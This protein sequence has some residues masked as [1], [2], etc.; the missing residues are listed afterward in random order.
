MA[1]ELTI[2]IKI[3]LAAADEF[4]GSETART[5]SAS[6]ETYYTTLSRYIAL[7]VQRERGQ[8]LGWVS[9]NYQPCKLGKELIDE[10]HIIGAREYGGASDPFCLPAEL[11]DLLTG[12]FYDNWD[13][14][15]AY[16]RYMKVKTKNPDCLAVLDEYLENSSLPDQIAVYYGVGRDAVKQLMHSLSMDGS[17]AAWRE[18]NGVRSASQLS[19][20]QFINRYALAM[21]KLTEELGI[22]AGARRIIDKA[23]RPSPTLTWKSYLLQ[24]VEFKSRQAKMK[25]FEE[26][27][28]CTG[29][30]EHDG[31]KALKQAPEPKQA[32]KT[33]LEAAVN[34][35][36]GIFVPVE[37]K[38][39]HKF[40][41]SGVIN[42]CFEPSL[43]IETWP[44]S[45]TQLANT[46]DFY[47]RLMNRFFA[48]MTFM[49]RVLIQIKYMANAPDQ[50]ADYIMMAPRAL[51][52]TFQGMHITTG[53]T[54]KNKPIR[55]PLTKW[56]LQQTNRRTHRQI[57]FYPNPTSAAANP[58]N[59]NSFGGLP[60]EHLLTPGEPDMTL[61]QPVLDHIR[62]ILGNGE[63]SHYEY[64]IN[65]F[66]AILQWKRKLGVILIY[67]GLQGA[68]KDIIIGDDGLLA[69]IY[70]KYHQ[71]LANIDYLLTNFNS[72]AKN[73]LFVAL[74]EVTPYNK[75]H[76]NNDQLKDIITGKILRVEQK[77]IDAYHIHDQRNFAAATNNPDGFKFEPHERRQY[78]AEVNNLYSGA[79]GKTHEERLRYFA[80]VLGCRDDRPREA[81]D[82]E[83]EE[84]AKNLYWFLMKRDL[85]SFNPR[86]FPSCNL[87]NDQQELHQEPVKE[88]LIAWNDG[89]ELKYEVH[90]EDDFGRTRR[91]TEQY[92][93][94]D[95]QIPFP[96][97][98]LLPIFKKYC[99]IQGERCDITAKVLSHRLK[100]YP[101]L[102]KIDDSKKRKASGQQFILKKILAY[103]NGDGS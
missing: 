103:R 85:T 97:S 74:D 89:L 66:A 79:G 53:F 26:C 9:V 52:E 40:S 61:I 35:A 75:S 11:N 44:E 102:V 95:F 12:R 25:V 84:V 59:F 98:S 23:E 88:F 65:W 8:S 47:M 14:S 96:A 41:L 17:E 19:S 100:R 71:K 78:I 49:P 50:V 58:H 81:T 73:K 54:A 86:E 99:E 94:T 4:L 28:V 39:P 72:D 67:Y 57:G 62:N 3:D 101:E 20:Y 1:F 38:E 55:E 70:G 60:F 32:L 37:L 91:V 64:Q 21:A 90:K 22:P 93:I 16:Q 69:I 48:T 10:C 18:K 6:G 13:D 80:K 31:M 56:W 36:V 63:E 92:K 42:D 46:L 33:K 51:Q 5:L 15:K 77:G 7:H 29:S 68:G 2:K 87:R 27:G 83:K 82:E 76:R 34:Q 43:F 24:E 45:A 30:Q